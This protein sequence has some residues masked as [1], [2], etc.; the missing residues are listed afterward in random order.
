MTAVGVTSSGGVG[1]SV[2]VAQTEATTATTFVGTDPISEPGPI[3]QLPEPFPGGFSQV[4][5]MPFNVTLPNPVPA[6]GVQ[7]EATEPPVRVGVVHRRRA[8]PSSST[9]TRST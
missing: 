5:D 1:T 7:F 3:E 9:S 8:G 2:A 4:F 6:T